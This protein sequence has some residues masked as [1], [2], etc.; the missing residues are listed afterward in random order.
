MLQTPTGILRLVVIVATTSVR[1]CQKRECLRSTQSSRAISFKPDVQRQSSGHRAR[2]SA[3][4]QKDARPG[5]PCSELLGWVLVER[6]F[7]PRQRQQFGARRVRHIFGLVRPLT[8]AAD[9][10]SDTQRLPSRDPEA[11]HRLDVL[12][13][14]FLGLGKCRDCRV[15]TRLAQNVQHGIG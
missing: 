9:R 12:L 15:H 13:I 11:A 6:Q 8:P 3:D 14:D 5:V 2:P 1:M 7:R 10:R 4:T